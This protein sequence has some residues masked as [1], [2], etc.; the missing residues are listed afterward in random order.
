[1]IKNN[2][3]KTKDDLI[4]DKFFPENTINKRKEPTQSLMF[5]YPLIGIHFAFQITE[6]ALVKAK[7]EFQ[8]QESPSPHSLGGI[9]KFYSLL[10]IL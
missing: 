4:Y 1:M 7:S 9:P 8:S 6:G 10:T 5:D 3:Y 2:S